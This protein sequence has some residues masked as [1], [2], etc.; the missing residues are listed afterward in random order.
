M[1]KCNYNPALVACALAAIGD[2]VN[3]I[4]IRLNTGGIDEDALNAIIAECVNAYLEENPIEGVQG[5]QGEPGA[6]GEPGED[7]VG[8]ASFKQINASDADDGYN[9][10]TVTLT[11]GA[12]IDITIKNGSKGSQGIKGEVG[13]QGPQGVQGEKGVKGDTG[14]TGPQGEPGYTPVKGTDYFTEDDQLSVAA[15]VKSLLNTEAW[16]FTLDDGTTLTKVVYVY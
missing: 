4:V 5:P 10:W 14:A 11:N 8:I 13:P 1:D 9:V 12:A 3:E 2:K 15:K 7:G 16:Q 6:D